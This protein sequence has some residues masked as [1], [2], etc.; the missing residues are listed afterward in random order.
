MAAQLS[1]D[2][3]PDTTGATHPNFPLILPDNIQTELDKL[4]LS[5]LST[6]TSSGTA[7]DVVNHSIGEYQ[8]FGSQPPRGY[9]ANYSKNNLPDVYEPTTN[10][11]IAS[12]N[13]T[14]GNGSIDV[15]LHET[16]H[17]YDADLGQASQSPAFVKAYNADVAT[18]A[19]DSYFNQQGNPT[20]YLSETFAESFAAFYSGAPAAA[21]YAAQHPNVWAYWT[22]RSGN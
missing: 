9:P 2:L 4:P 21:Q 8:N 18:F 12:K 1:R 11:V 14:Q 20:G 3:N 17:A 6:L 19:N 10:P 7:W 22:S 16:G 13:P 5:V 15:V